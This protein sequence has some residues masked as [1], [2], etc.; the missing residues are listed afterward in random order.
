MISTKGRYGLRV[1]LD[2]SQQES[3]EYISLKSISQRQDISMK[4]L[5]MIVASLNKS[6]LL[7]SQRG[8][9][10]GY[11]LTKDPSEYTVGEIIRA[12]EGKLC[13][14]SCQ[15]CEGG[16]E[17]CERSET[18]LTMPIWKKLDLMV[19]SCLDEMTLADVLNG[20]I[21]PLNRGS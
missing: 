3:G 19:N 4:Y 17:K 8:K 16:K 5:E 20:D 15:G 18:C 11:M 21:S 9:D 14:V 7:K 1:M 10:G 6:G 12:A 13:A 2:I